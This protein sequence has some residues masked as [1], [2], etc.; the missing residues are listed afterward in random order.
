MGF[1]LIEIMAALVVFAV[2]IISIISMQV[3]SIRQNA[4]S[5]RIGIGTTLAQDKME[6]IMWK[7]QTY[8]SADYLTQNSPCPTPGSAICS[9]AP[10]GCFDSVMFQGYDYTRCWTINKPSAPPFN[11]NIYVNWS[12]KSIQNRNIN[13]MS[14]YDPR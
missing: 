13:L 10:V 7:Y 11:L 6:D 8:F 2:G 9:G 12:D 3:Q 4:F 14:R 1:T 5:N